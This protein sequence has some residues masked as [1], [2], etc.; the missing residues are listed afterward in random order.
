MAAQDEAARVVCGECHSSTVASCSRDDAEVWGQVDYW[1]SP[2]ET[3][4][5][6]MGDCEDFAI[7]KYFTL[8]A[9]GVPLPGCGWSTCARRSAARRPV[10]AHMV[11]AYYPAPEDDP[12]I[13]DNLV[14]DVR[15]ARRSAPT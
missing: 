1:A 10:Q 13:L 3:L 9:L 5:S 15:P 2:L 11:L 6:G 12:L 7:A 4:Q 8:L 14:A